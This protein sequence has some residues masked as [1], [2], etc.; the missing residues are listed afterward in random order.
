MYTDVK[1]QIDYCISDPDTK[2]DHL[3]GDAVNYSL[4]FLYQQNIYDL[5]QLSFAEERI[6]LSSMGNATDAA[7]SLDIIDEAGTPMYQCTL[8]HSKDMYDMDS[9][10]RFYDIYNR[11]VQEMA[12]E[13]EPERRLVEDL[14]KKK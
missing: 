8:E 1:Q 14:L 12:E 4:F 13:K 10:Q 7:V 5:T 3:Y 6:E 11:I 2:L 9:I